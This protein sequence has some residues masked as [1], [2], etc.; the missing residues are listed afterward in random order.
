M[1]AATVQELAT[2]PD[3]LHSRAEL[4]Q[5]ATTQAQQHSAALDSEKAAHAATAAE[6]ATVKGQL[7][8]EVTAHT[9]TQTALNAATAKLSA[10]ESALKAAGVAITSAEK[11]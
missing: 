4:A 2:S 9:A 10:L 6:L 3:L 1:T 11:T 7:V 5:L 8:Q